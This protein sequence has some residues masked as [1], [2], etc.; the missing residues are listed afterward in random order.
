LCIEALNVTVV[1]RWLE[2]ASEEEIA[3]AIDLPS[4]V[5][6]ALCMAAA[7]R[8]DHETGI[9]LFNSNLLNFMWILPRTYLFSSCLWEILSFPFGFCVLFFFPIK[10]NDSYYSF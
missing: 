6:T 4:S 8:K 7:L 5:G 3:G 2:V 10:W 9:S 1:K